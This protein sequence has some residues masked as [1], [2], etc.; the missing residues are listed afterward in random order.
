M[1]G[2]GRRRVVVGIIDR[3]GNNACDCTVEEGRWVLRACLRGMSLMFIGMV[4]PLVAPPD[5]TGM[6]RRVRFDTAC[7]CT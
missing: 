5:R 6:P 4:A 1:R 3:R 7:G 2:A